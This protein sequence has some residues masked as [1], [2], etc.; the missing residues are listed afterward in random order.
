MGNEGGTGQR[1][2]WQWRPR[3]ITQGAL[4]GTL[5]SDTPALTILRVLTLPGKCA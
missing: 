4:G 3:P 1:E 2:K 5:Y